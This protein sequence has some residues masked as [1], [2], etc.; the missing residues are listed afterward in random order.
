VEITVELENDQNWEEKCYQVGC[1]LASE[2]ARQWL[3][4]MEERLFQER[5]KELS[6]FHL[7]RSCRYG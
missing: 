2:I 6:G 3:K 5:D 1:Q 7:A 4:A